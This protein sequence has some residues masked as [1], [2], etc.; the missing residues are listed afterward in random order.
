MHIGLIGGIG[1]AATDYYYRGLI[2]AAATLGRDLELTLA[3]ADTPT[4]LK[5]LADD[6]RLKQVGIYE[7][8]TSRLAAA[9]AECVV[10]TSIAGHFCIEEFKAISPLP[11]IDITKVILDDLQSAGI[12]TVGILGTSAAMTTGMYSKLEPVRVLAPLGNML[13]DVHKAYVELAQSG[14][15]TDAQV[16][17]FVKAGRGLLD[18]GSQAILL[19]GTDLN[20][21]FAEQTYGLP[22]VDCAG[23]HLKAIEDM[24]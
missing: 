5:N 24:V 13:A 8:L 14:N 20:A 11:V 15:P 10:V 2:K 23:L 6:D 1:P 19:G 7:R 16:D 17:T 22:L 3:H 18:Q 12:H 4:L 9:G 21:I